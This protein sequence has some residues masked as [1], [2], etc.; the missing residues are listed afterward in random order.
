MNNLTHLQDRNT[1]GKIYVKNI[2]KKNIKIRNQL[3]S[4]K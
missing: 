2:I 1:K 3:K 4:T